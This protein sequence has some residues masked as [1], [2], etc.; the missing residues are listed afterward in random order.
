[1]SLPV[2]DQQFTSVIALSGSERYAHLIKRVADAEEIWSL[3]GPDGWAL[4]GDAEREL[5]P[6]WPHPRY[7]A[8]CAADQWSGAQPVAIPLV[9]WLTAW[10]PGLE[11]D[12]RAV[13]V[14]PA[15][16][17]KGVVVEAARL[18]ADLEAERSR[19]D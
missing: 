10:L 11:G 13:A 1:M 16:G 5:V 6:V 14:F 2:S 15:P 12:G 9:E 18:R 8:A 17:A 3:R 7:A 19:Y 4:A